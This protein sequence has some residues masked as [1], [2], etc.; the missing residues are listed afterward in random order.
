[1]EDNKINRINLHYLPSTQFLY[2]GKICSTIDMEKDK[3]EEP[4]V[5]YGL[6]YYWTFL[7]TYMS[8]IFRLGWLMGFLQHAVC[9]DGH[10]PKTK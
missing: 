1:M 2:G 6:P 7:L 8:N 10:N 4:T 5:N 3:H 9:A